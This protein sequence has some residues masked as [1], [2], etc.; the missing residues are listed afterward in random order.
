MIYLLKTISLGIFMYSCL[1]M[2]SIVILSITPD[3]IHLP[4]GIITALVSLILCSASSRGRKAGFIEKYFLVIGA[5]FSV[6]ESFILYELLQHSAAVLILSVPYYIYLWKLGWDLGDIKLSHDEFKL[7]FMTQF[8]ILLPLT[9]AATFFPGTMMSKEMGQYFTAFVIISPIILRYS[10][11]YMY[12]KEQKNRKA[13]IINILSTAC[14]LLALLFVSSADFISCMSVLINYIS[15]GID[16][17]LT[18]IIYIISYPIGYV[19]YLLINF[20]Q[21]FLK[22][23][24]SILD[25]LKPGDESSKQPLDISTVPIPSAL[26][27]ILKIVIPIILA[28][29]LIKVLSRRITKSAKA[30]FSESREFVFS[31]SEVGK[32]IG[33][34]LTSIFKRKDKVEPVTISEKIRFLYSSFLELSMRKGIYNK[35]SQTARDVK[36]KSLLYVGGCCDDIEF[37][38]H[39]YEKTRYSE[40]SPLQ[41]DLDSADASFKKL[42]ETYDKVQ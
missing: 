39:I 33:K 8:K 2:V 18:F 14:L 24:A 4:A 25:N 22:P 13:Y 1:Y 32:G 6:I 19:I 41:D 27:L 21:K 20:L 3:R 16:K 15:I 12:V 10:R 40:D 11:D 31:L 5:V 37:L 38:T 36:E 23:D 30:D 7:Q 29:T 42:K 26:I 35:T 9:I 17:V 34:N 28:V